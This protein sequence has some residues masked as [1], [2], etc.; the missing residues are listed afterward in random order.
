MAEFY[1]L[2]AEFPDE[3]TIV[4]AA[5]QARRTGYLKFDAFTPFPVTRL[6]HV[7]GIKDSRPAWLGLTGGIV[8]FLLA[9][10]MQAFVSFSY[11]LNVGGRPIYPLSAFAV[12]IFELTILFAVLF[13]FVGLLILN[14]LPRLNYPIFGA[15]RFRLASKDRFFL[16]IKADDKQFDRDRTA[17]FLSDLGAVSVALVPS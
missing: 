12:V 10:G 14:G 6:A 11:P 9:L 4:N 8:G 2:L 13:L 3:E 17:D 15:P 16:C 5:K 1:G 7:M